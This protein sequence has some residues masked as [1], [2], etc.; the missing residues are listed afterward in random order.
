MVT[1]LLPYLRPTLKSKGGGLVVFVR[2]RAGDNS[3]GSGGGGSDNERIFLTNIFQISAAID[4]P[5]FYRSLL[6]RD[7]PEKYKTVFSSALS[8]LYFL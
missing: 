7:P 4:S 5:T 1:T 2:W 6:F 8:R 3:I